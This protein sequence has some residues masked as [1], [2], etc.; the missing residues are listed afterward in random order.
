MRPIRLQ[1]SA[2]LQA[3]DRYWAAAW[4][5]LEADL[6]VWEAVLVELEDVFGVEEVEE[7]VTEHAAWPHTGFRLD[8]ELLVPDH[9]VQ[10]RRQNSRRRTFW[11]ACDALTMS[12]SCRTRA[13]CRRDLVTG[14]TPL[15]FPAR[16]WKT[17][18][19]VNIIHA[20]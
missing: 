1:L 4:L 7:V 20:T 8:R 12:V 13:T 3:A 6:K 18:P 17:P 10:S 5:D 11:R 2:V 15:Q 9:R 14:A 16:S 19:Y